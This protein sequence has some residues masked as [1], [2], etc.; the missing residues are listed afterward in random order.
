M[1]RNYRR[2]YKEYV[3]RVHYEFGG[4]TLCGIKRLSK[5]RT[6]TTKTKDDVTC[7]VC[8]KK[9]EKGNYVKEHFE[10]DIFEI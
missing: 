7:H 6:F 8:K 3:P 1:S 9:L 10:G 5:Y 4:A 2:E